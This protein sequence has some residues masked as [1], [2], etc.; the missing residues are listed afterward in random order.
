MACHPPLAIGYIGRAV[1]VCGLGAVEP[2]MLWCG[3]GDVV[4]IRA[5]DGD[6]IV[7]VVGH[8]GLFRK[9][10]SRR[11]ISAH[12]GELVVHLSR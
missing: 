9:W 5:A 10:R 3:C 8:R 2:L 4:A 7:I 6:G 1:F 11:V 12:C